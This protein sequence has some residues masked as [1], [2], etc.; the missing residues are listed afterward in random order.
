VPEACGGRLCVPCNRV[1]PHATGR[2]LV[3]PIRPVRKTNPI[4]GFRQLSDPVANRAA[5]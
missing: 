3:H 4:H 5:V 2:N 1:Q